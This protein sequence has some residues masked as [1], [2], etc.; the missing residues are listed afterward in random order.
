MSITACFDVI[1]LI[2]FDFFLLFQPLNIFSIENF[3]ISNGILFFKYFDIK[4]E[5]HTLVSVRT[6]EILFMFEFSSFERRSF[7]VKVGL[8][9]DEFNYHRF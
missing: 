9:L 1:M 4:S 5:S 6:A 7:A 3:G 2:S 8:T